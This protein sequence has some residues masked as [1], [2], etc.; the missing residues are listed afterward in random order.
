M[1]NT[2]SQ[3]KR[4]NKFVETFGNSRN[5]WDARN[6]PASNE[7]TQSDMTSFGMGSTTIS[8]LLGSGSRTARTRQMIYEKWAVMESDPIV[9]TALK[10]LCTAALG[11]HE[12]SGD[13]IFIES[14]P[15]LSK[16]DKR[17]YYI[18]EIKADLIPL[19]NKIAFTNSYQAAAF[20]DSYVR[21]HSNKNG[22]QDLYNGELVHPTLVQ[23][24]ERGSRTV[25]Y[26][27]NTG[28]KNFQ[29]LNSLQMARMQMQRT[30][31]IPQVG[32]VEKSLRYSLE[33]DDADNLPL[34]PA[35]VGGSYLYAAE[36]PYDALTA[37]LL[38]LV[39]QRWADSIDE[40]ILTVDMENM[41]KGQ[42]EKFLGSVVQM[43]Q[44]SKQ[45]AENA[46][47]RNKPVMERIRHLI[48][49]I[50]GQK[51]Q[52][53]VIGNAGGQRSANISIEDVMLH[54][55]LLAGVFG[56]DLSMIGFA[57]QL[58]GGLG[59]GG[60]FRTS[61]QMGE[62]SRVI[63]TAQTDF[64]NSIID[65]HT[66]KK[67]GFVFEPKKRPFNLNFYGSISALENEKQA[68]RANAMNG[69]LMLVQAIQQFKE[70]G[71]SQEMMKVFL[72]QTMLLDENIADHYS[73]IVNSTGGNE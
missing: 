7:I 6:L 14:N 59:D 48:P 22:I 1:K 23:P 63:R 17:N 41:D 12:T 2:S 30:Q 33:V 11:G 43:L 47:K 15:D 20:G 5:K 32:V 42:Q 19:F 61:A 24:F 44:K 34:M 10:I 66:Y 65:V 49:V 67:Y 39:G 53:N 29:R 50:G 9:S 4:A 25:G 31:W 72:T 3:A 26:A 70:L 8:T 54:A 62:S 13:I 57:D 21:I 56:T 60:F 16:T 37:S 35:M 64:Y 46:V 45:I 52:L 55:R 38:G 18:D 51:Q 69:G 28:E 40:Q 68:T 71:A 73:Q 27:I 36:T 58:S